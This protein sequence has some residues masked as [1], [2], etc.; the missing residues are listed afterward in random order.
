MLNIIGAH[1]LSLN[2]IIWQSL[3]NLPNHQIKNLAKVSR[4]MVFCYIFCVEA[5]NKTLP[6]CTLDKISDC[7]LTSSTNHEVCDIKLLLASCY[8]YVA[9]PPELG[10]TLHL[11]SIGSVQSQTTIRVR[12]IL[13]D[14]LLGFFP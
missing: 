3:S 8:Q 1:T 5:S 9:S 12:K 2:W 4:H 10:Q 13:T 7:S 6:K 14:K 11:L